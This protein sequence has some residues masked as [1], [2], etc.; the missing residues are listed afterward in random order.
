MQFKKRDGLLCAIFSILTCGLYTIYFWYRYGED[1]NVICAEDGKETQNYIVAWLLSIVTCGIY[2]I[3]WLY[4]VGSRLDTA[5]KKYD[6]NVESPVFFT[7]FMNIPFLSFMYAC[8]I[9][10]KFQDRYMEM[11]PGGDSGYGYGGYGGPVPPFNG[12]GSVPPQNGPS[13]PIPPYTG[14]KGLKPQPTAPPYHNGGNGQ[15]MGQ[16]IGSQ[17]KSAVQEMGSGIKNSAASAMPACKN[18]GAIVPPGKNY[19]KRCG[20][21][22]NGPA[23]ERPQ[24]NPAVENAEVP[25]VPKKPMVSSEPV[26][27][28]FQ[29]EVKPE[30]SQINE[31]PELKWSGEPKTEESKGEVPKVE[32]SVKAEAPVCPRCGGKVKPGDRFCIHCGSKIS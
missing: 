15:S 28:E 25:N 3:Y 11:H 18:C 21:P 23:P 7:L 5:S 24:G 9:M 10:N 30:T 16:Q 1:V 22:V 20:Y 26:K 32:Q 6:V 2:G 27:P 4:N 17:L 19:C 12:G 31:K 13:G 14:G 8:D 29:A